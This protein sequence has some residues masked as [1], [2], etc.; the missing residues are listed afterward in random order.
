M[1]DEINT[2]DLNTKFLT[3]GQ[4]DVTDLTDSG[5]VDT[6]LVKPDPVESD[7]VLSDEVIEYEEINDVEDVQLY[8]KGGHHPVHLG[9][10]YHED[11]FEVIHKLGYG[12][13]GTV[14]FCRDHIAQKWRALKF[15]T[16]DQSVNNNEE[17][18]FELLQAHSTPEQLE[19]NHIAVPLDK[20]WV[21]GP[22]GRHLCFV[23]PVLG[24]PVTDWRFAQKSELIQGTANI[25]D[26][27]RQ[28]IQGLS[29]L[30]A[31]GLCHGDLRPSNILMRIEG[32]D[33]MDEEE[34]MELME[35]PCGVDILTEDGDLPGPRA[36]EYVVKNADSYWSEK[37]T[38]RSIAI[39]DFGEAFF[40][41][42]PPKRLGIPIIYAAPEALFPGCGQASSATD[43]WSLACTL[44]E[45]RTSWPLFDS[46]FGG[47]QF[48]RTVYV[49]ERVLGPLPQ[50]YRTGCNK[51]H[52]RRL[53]HYRRS[54]AKSTQESVSSDS[55]SSVEM[56]S[57]QRLRISARRNVPRTQ[58]S[59]VFEKMLGEE[60]QV[61]IK[62]PISPES[63][64]EWIRCEYPRDDILGLA[65]LL[66]KMFQY[67]PD[68]R[69][70][71]EEVCAHPW[72][73]GTAKSSTPRTETKRWKYV[74]K[75][76]GKLGL[77]LVFLMMACLLWLQLVPYHYSGLN[78][79][80]PWPITNQS[81]LT[82]NEPNPDFLAEQ[83]EA[84]AAKGTCYCMEA[85]SRIFQTGVEGSCLVTK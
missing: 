19:E 28:V 25:Q 70:T 16:A 42:E 64:R 52:R 49:I 65:E 33:D 13:F 46:A 80:E 63:K 4:S 7:P 51:L 53:R 32:L 62:P 30:H 81:G 17:R 23:M 85:P 71:I 69:I 10:F 77:F 39:I 60:R 21:E 56:N 50:P 55:D 2:D 54:R 74:G 59:E 22:N 31:R 58:Y 83:R 43:I 34:I 18:M 5:A 47:G 75:P 8:N 40:R 78:T 6:G 24:F 76:L 73:G 82:T 67:D 38:T 12:G 72:A 61:C 14:W 37:L 66:G 1:T 79:N 26:V 44:W 20:F 3:Q 41:N 48:D 11:R 9:D 45:I 57:Q 29:F 35:E 68:A 84:M 36:P 27:C 15:L